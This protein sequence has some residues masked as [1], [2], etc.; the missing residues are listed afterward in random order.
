MKKKIIPIFILGFLLVLAGCAAG[1]NTLI[2]SGAADEIAGFWRGIWHGIIA[3]IAFIISLFSDKINIYEV[4]NNGGW[5]NFGFLLGLCVFCNGGR[6]KSRK[7]KKHKHKKAT[8]S[9]ASDKEKSENDSDTEYKAEIIIKKTRKTA[10]TE[11]TT[12]IIIEPETD[13]QAEA[14]D[15]AETIIDS[16]KKDT[17]QTL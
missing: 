2:N 7:H 17:D 15:T 5:Y 4:H 9:C 13:D 1:P 10:D 3:P 6:R 8:F 14:E 12:E 16:E 11:D